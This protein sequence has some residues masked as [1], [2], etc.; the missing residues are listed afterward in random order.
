[1]SQL[2]TEEDIEI[3]NDTEVSVDDEDSDDMR[4][5]SQD[6]ID[7]SICISSQEIEINRGCCGTR[8]VDGVVAFYNRRE[9]AQSET[10][11]GL[12]RRLRQI[13]NKLC[14]PRVFEVNDHG[15][16]TEFS[17]KGETIGSWV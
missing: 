10:H 4:C 7:E 2:A 17:Y 3:C 6:E 5:P 14:W 11:Q 12:F 15:N 13:G 9:I 8:R 16:V 1:M